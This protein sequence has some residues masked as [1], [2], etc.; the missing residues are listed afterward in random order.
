MPG[1]R[2]PLFAVP[3][4]TPFAP[5]LAQWMLAD[6]AGPEALARQLLILPSRRAV[7]AVTDAFLAARPGP[8]AL[9]LPRMVPV[10]DLDEAGA[11][12]LAIAGLDAE[13]TLPPPMGRLARRLRLAAILERAGQARGSRA[14]AL[15]GELAAVLDTLAIEQVPL[16]S[17]REAGDALPAAHWQ[18]NR[19]I[20]ATVAEAWEGIAAE[21]GHSDP[22]ARREAELALLARTWRET[23]LEEL[24]TIA[25]FSAAPPAVRALM[26]AALDLPNGRVLLSGFD[27]GMT[28]AD[29]AALR[30]AAATPSGRIAAGMHPQTGLLQ[31]L[32]AC[33]AA[34]EDVQLVGDAGQP[35]PA[36]LRLVAA[37]VSPADLPASTTASPAGAAGLTLLEAESS[38]EEALAIALAMRQALETPGR[39]AAL[40]TPDRGLARR[41]AGQLQRFGIAIGDSAG[42]P[43]ALTAPGRLLMALAETAATDF[44]PVPLVSL[45]RHPLLADSREGA[46]ANAWRAG[47]AALDRALRG[48]RPAPGL[49]G[50]GAKIAAAKE[51]RLPDWWQGMALPL[52]RPLDGLF[53][54]GAVPLGALIE[55]LRAAATGLAGERPWAGPE[56]QALARLFAEAAEA[57]LPVRARDAGAVLALLMEGEAVR[58]PFRQHPRLAILGL[59]EAR[60]QA[61]DLLIL[62]GLNEGSWPGSVPP[63]PWLAPAL[64]RD[65]GLPA[66]E[67]RI[68]AQAGDFLALASHAGEVL[69]TRAKRGE[70]GPEAAS[71]FL[72]KLKVAAGG[73]LVEA[74]ELLALARALDRPAKVVPALRPAPCPP[75]GARPKR[76]S[77]SAADMLAA[78]PFSFWAQRILKVEPL[79]PLDSDPTAA[80]RGTA[81]HE[82][83]ERWLG[84]GEDRRA[85]TE[86][87]LAA[88]GGGPAA[89]LLWRPRVEAMLDWVEEQLARDRKAG[90]QPI[91]FE[92]GGEMIVEGVRLSGKADRVDAKEGVL[93]ILDYKTG[94]A[95]SKAQAVGGWALQL[96]VLA[97]LAEAGAFAGVAPAATTLLAYAMLRGGAGTP[98]EMRGENWNWNREAAE[99]R[100]REI[101]GNYLTGN[102]SFPAKV[103]PL[104]AERY[105]S[106]DHLARLQEWFGR[107]G[108][109]A[110]DG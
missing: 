6:A 38:H 56:G 23:K 36:R 4:G 42:T 77:A 22:V 11:L 17:L 46:E 40:A 71:R 68:G 14:L 48:T 58:L 92:I 2:L 80:E 84:K 90:W 52:L 3:A 62:G 98:G 21:A 63:D 107:D 10:G 39:T 102:A 28:E 69:L 85:A 76:L 86:A 55:A 110:P 31:I 87:A 5:A 29:W 27:P 13:A 9:L 100:L 34:P 18:R 79:E 30:D 108:G 12:D 25:G 99:A 104:Y 72:L 33:G 53:A 81:V 44:A 41:V 32:E 26:A 67:A 20:L 54:G 70:A 94:S 51:A 59:L 95:P 82:I 96:P 24:V 65:L 89:D 16:A 47:A 50:I 49:A 19:A 61:A 57:S 97:R 64:R 7:A 73:A 60:L 37:A 109:R 43:L 105:R 75:A 106:F 93:R 35:A 1:R 88:V 78:D 91:A 103:H 15:A 101:I 83:L 8:G 74:R 66:A 45:L